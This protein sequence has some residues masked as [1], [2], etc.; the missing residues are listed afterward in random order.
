MS[1][2][3]SNVLDAPPAF[4][5]PGL[6]PGGTVSRQSRLLTCWTEEGIAENNHN[7]G[8]THGVGAE[9]LLDNTHR[10][11]VLTSRYGF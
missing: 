3:P 7:L 6:F 5:P 1:Y 9:S 11:R 2:N 4:A 10:T 8:S